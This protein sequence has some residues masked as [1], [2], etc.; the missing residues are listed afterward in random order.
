MYN[1]FGSNVNY[2]HTLLLGSTEQLSSCIKVE[3]TF[4]EKLVDDSHT[5]VFKD[6]E[7]ASPGA[8]L[9]LSSLVRQG[10]G[11]PTEFAS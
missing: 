9:Y 7:K 11:P 8:G 2:N 10:P 3:V 1:F 4:L 5:K 6:L